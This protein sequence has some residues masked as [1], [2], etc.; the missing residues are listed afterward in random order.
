MPRSLKV[1]AEVGV[2]LPPWAT[3]TEALIPGKP[4]LD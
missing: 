1:F 2:V 3:V 4:S